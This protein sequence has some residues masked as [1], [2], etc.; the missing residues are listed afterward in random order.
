MVTLQKYSSIKNVTLM[1]YFYICCCSWLL[2]IIRNLRGGDDILYNL[3]L[4]RRDV[5]RWAQPIPASRCIA[6]STKFNT[7]RY[8][9]Q[10]LLPFLGLKWENVS[11]YLSPPNPIWVNS[12]TLYL[13]YKFDNP[14]F[15][16]SLSVNEMKNRL[17]WAFTS[18]S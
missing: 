6:S 10:S 16:I 17:P 11:V 4:Y 18:R 12:Y 2:S 3:Q 5:H 7:K 15:S 9:K 1:S 13:S 14:N 8:V